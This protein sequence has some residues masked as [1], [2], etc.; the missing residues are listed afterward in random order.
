MR[1]VEDE[2]GEENFASAF[3][4]LFLLDIYSVKRELLTKKRHIL[5]LVIDRP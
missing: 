4:Y 5:G 1:R 2:L 3:V